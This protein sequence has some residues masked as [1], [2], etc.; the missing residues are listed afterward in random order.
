MLDI[1]KTINDTEALINSVS[2][3]AK[4]ISDKETRN[5][6]DSWV[7]NYS[8]NILEVLDSH[9]KAVAALLYLE[10]SLTM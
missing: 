9:P 1:E 4:T 5:K 10:K 7:A 3:S 6:A 2:K 8:N